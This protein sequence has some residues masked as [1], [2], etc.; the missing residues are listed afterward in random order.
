MSCV[1]NSSHTDMRNIVRVTSV[2]SSRSV[3]SGELNMLLEEAEQF[4][5][6][7]VT[8]E[9]PLRQKRSD[10]TADRN[11][12]RLSLDLESA[13]Q[14]NITKRRSTTPWKR[15]APSGLFRKSNQTLQ[16]PVESNPLLPTQ[17]SNESNP[18]L[19]TTT[20]MRPRDG[21]RSTRNSAKTA[22]AVDEFY[23]KKIQDLFNQFDF[24]D[25]DMP[26]KEAADQE[27]QAWLSSI[28]LLKA[29]VKKFFLSTTLWG[30][31]CGNVKTDKSIYKN[32]TTN[33]KYCPTYSNDAAKMQKEMLIAFK[34]GFQVAI[35]LVCSQYS[36]LQY[37]GRYIN[38]RNV[39]VCK[40]LE[41]ERTVGNGMY[42]LSWKK[43]IIHEI[44][45]KE[46]VSQ[47][48]R[49]RSNI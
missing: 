27:S 28:A 47:K 40:Q 26:V 38:H 18:V 30:A 44:E 9:A 12:K 10:T 48:L 16:V 1:Y 11:S 6:D 42:Y 4:W 13:S 3:S 20:M 31:A 32:G 36:Q 14:I 41:K 7:A 29:D 17:I 49:D 23:H 37:T 43:T 46:D 35:F 33:P 39:L 25:K 5:F 2:V 45:T 8:I 22:Y 19:P 34:D 21:A 24:D 15:T